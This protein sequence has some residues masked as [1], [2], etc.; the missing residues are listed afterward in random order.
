MPL[1]VKREV[2]PIKNGFASHAVDLKMAAHGYS[3]EVADINL[4]RVIHSFLA[5][6]ER[7]GR[8]DE[9]LK[10]YGGTRDDDGAVEIILAPLA[11]PTSPPRS[12]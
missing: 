7:A 3:P 9:I 8:L 10:N 5:P 4:V 11:A 6:F 1:R 12:R 2:R